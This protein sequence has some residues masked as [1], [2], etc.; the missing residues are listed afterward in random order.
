MITKEK[1]GYVEKEYRMIVTT[2][3]QL[4]DGRIFT[5]ERDQGRYRAECNDY[6]EFDFDTIGWKNGKSFEC[7]FTQEEIQ[8]IM[9][10][11][12]NGDLEDLIEWSI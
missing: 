10:I 4:Q 7:N 8:D 1:L 11:Y 3:I 6:D 12:H 9:N 5:V 2:S